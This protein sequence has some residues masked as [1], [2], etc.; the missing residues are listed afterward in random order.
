MTVTPDLAAMFPGPIETYI[1]E[2]ATLE[3]LPAVAIG[4]CLVRNQE[5]FPLLRQLIARAT[6]APIATENQA[7]QLFRALHILGGGRDS[8]SFLPMLRLLQGPPDDIDWLLG[9]A[10]TD[11]LKKIA[12]GVFDGNADALFEAILNQDLDG[13]VRGSLLGAATYLA[14]ERRIDRELMIAFLERFAGEPSVPGDDLV[15]DAWAQAIALLGLRHLEPLVSEAEKDERLD[16]FLF[17]RADFEATLAAA[18]QAP[19]DK[20]RFDDA[21]LGYIDDVL[22]ALEPFSYGHDEEADD[23]GDL[24]TGSVSEPVTNPWR[25][26]GR[27]DPCPCGSGKKAKRCCLAA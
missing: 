27:N 16:D 25:H 12:A 14:W 18:E 9:D 26:V 4:V 1:G 5:A 19:D 13:S 24:D 22:V 8:A 21:N 10:S 17:I 3:E 11:T 15:W 7:T 23:F 20:T 6:D 2:L